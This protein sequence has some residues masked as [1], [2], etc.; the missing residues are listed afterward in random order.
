[1]KKSALILPQKYVVRSIDDKRVYV[2]LRTNIKSEVNGNQT[3]Y[4]YDE[5]RFELPKRKNINQYIED[6]FKSL[7]ELGKEIELK[8]SAWHEQKEIINKLIDNH[9]LIDVL[10][11]LVNKILELE[12]KIQLLE[13]Q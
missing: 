8:E 4:T 2:I 9:E 11:F 13:N 3:V 10:Q 7:I 1:M 5:Y 12:I 6:N